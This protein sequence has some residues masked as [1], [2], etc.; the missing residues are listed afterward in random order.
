MRQKTGPPADDYRIRCPRL[1][2]QIA[3][4]YCRS[5][6]RGSPCFKIL[7]C[8]FNYFAV[9]EYLRRELVPAEWENLVKRE[10]KPKV[11]SL[12]ELIEEAKQSKREE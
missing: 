6:N 9:E 5:E 12:M 7:D 3:F 1:G 8:W 11:I 10:V 2:Q 4:S